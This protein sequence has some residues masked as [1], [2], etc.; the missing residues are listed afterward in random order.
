VAAKPGDLEA[1][2]LKAEVKPGAEYSLRI[3]TMVE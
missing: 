2:P 3:D 1:R